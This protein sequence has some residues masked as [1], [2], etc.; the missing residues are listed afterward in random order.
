MPQFQQQQ[1]QQPSIVYQQNGCPPTATVGTTLHSPSMLMGLR[2]DGST[3]GVAQ[4]NAAAATPQ[5][6]P[7]STAYQYNDVY[8]MSYPVTPAA[9]AAT[10]QVSYPQDPGGNALAYGQRQPV[11]Q[12]SPVSPSSE[13]DS[14]M[15][16][17]SPIPNIVFTGWYFI[18]LVAL[19][20]CIFLIYY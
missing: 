1:D 17:K 12:S 16:G 2:G 8:M 6:S 13:H 19:C 20:R 10:A 3:Y 7:A 14:P 4:A 9:A 11:V 18:K 15:A 5:H